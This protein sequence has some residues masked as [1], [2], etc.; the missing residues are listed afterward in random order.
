[1]SGVPRAP[2]RSDVGLAAALTAFATAELY[3]SYAFERVPADGP[4]LIHFVVAIATGAALAWRRVYPL[5]VAPAVFALV[6]VQ[7]AFVDQPNVYG[8]IIVGVVAL[9]SL[10]AHTPSRRQ[11]VGVGA[12]VLALGFVS[13]LRDPEDAFGS[14]ATNALFGAGVLLA[15]FIVRRQRERADEMRRQ[16]DLAD[17]RS[18]EIAATERARIARELH[19]VVAH[20]MSVVVLQARGARR[21]ID[22]DPTR[23]CRALD[24]IERVAS[25][26]LDEMRRLL[27]ILRTAD[28][29]TA[30]MAPQPKLYEL[31]V[32]VEQ[33]R[34]SGASVDLVIEGEARDLAPAIELSAYRIAQEALTNALKH[35]PGSHARL[36]VRY[37]ADSV[38][39][40]VLDDGPG[41]VPARG[42]HGLIGMRERVELFGGSFAAGAEPDGGFGVRAR[43]P[44]PEAAS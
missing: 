35:A 44:I 13:G 4:S 33:A 31:P 28:P 42:G 22:A 3:T 5:V 23:A 34:A 20:G 17:E 30:P 14:A 38:A 27:G 29:E 11:A 19:D 21:I 2:S 1:M 9:Y 15:G 24:D 41:G 25:D 8:E 12:V 10:A 37:D 43:L 39:I 6:A 32:L 18:R 16:R 36:C 7:P 26:C 40:E